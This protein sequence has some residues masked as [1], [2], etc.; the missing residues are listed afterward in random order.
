MAVFISFAVA[1]FPAPDVVQNSQARLDP[2]NVVGAIK[3][4]Q[5]ATWQWQ[6]LMGVP[7]T[8]NRKR[9]LRTGDL[10]YRLYVLQQ[11]RRLAIRAKRRAHN[12]PHEPEWRCLQQHE[13]SWRDAWDPYWGGLQMDRSFMLSHAPRHLLSRG[14]A[15][16][17]TALE[18][19]W[20]AERALRAGRG[21]YPWA[22]TARLCGLI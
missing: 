17:W 4:Y 1:G 3:R 14:W 7:K 20:V 18:Q 15:N 12:P 21:F 8:P 16:R 10:E 22:N 6:R 5:R 2:G 11:W 9:Y 13:G 19:M